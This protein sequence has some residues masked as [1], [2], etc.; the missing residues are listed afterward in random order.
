M[1]IKLAQRQSKATP[2]RGRGGE[3]KQVR[4]SWGK[5]PFN[6]G[7]GGRKF[8]QNSAKK[9]Q[10]K[11]ETIPE[12]NRT[13]HWRRRAGRKRGKETQQSEIA[14]G[15]ACGFVFARKTWQKNKRQNWFL[16][17]FFARKEGRAERRGAEQSAAGREQQRTAVKRGQVEP[18][19][20]ILQGKL[21]QKNSNRKTKML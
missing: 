18:L 19:A 13:E 16:A 2:G 12:A 10:K 6:R 15:D 14:I 11:K 20:E 4:D 3:G 9:T 1:R 8:Q 7:A 21:T 17:Q 5:Q